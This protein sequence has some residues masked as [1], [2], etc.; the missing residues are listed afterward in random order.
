MTRRSRAL[1][2]AVILSAVGGASLVAADQGG[3]G[4]QA[5][6]ET[7][8]T[9]KLELTFEDEFDGIR[10]NRSKWT[11]GE[12]GDLVTSRTMSGNAERQVYFD[13]QY[14]NLGIQPVS[15]RAGVLRITAQPMTPAQRAAVARQ[16]PLLPPVNQSP[17]LA[18]LSYSSGRIT[19]QNRFSQRYGYFEVRARF[20]AGRG[21]WPA[22]W[23]LPAAGGWPPEIDIMEALGH[24]PDTVYATT[25]SAALPKQ[26]VT[27]KLRSADDG[28]HRY[29]VLWGPETIDVY[30]DGLKTGSV[31]TPADAHQPM[32]FIANLAVG[33]HW[34]GYPDAG[35]RFPATMDI[36]YVRAWKLPGRAPGR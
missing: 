17:V 26:T 21:L 16:L 19:T 18:E 5:A 13:P 10:L 6:R 23:L 32:Y 33:G 36:D 25:H 7:I 30:V 20:S 11:Q 14:L 22:L 35:T 1:F 27:T 31:K 29:G 3:S 9:S 12:Q 15:V 28:Y 24:D 4:V 34:P 8:D 2:T